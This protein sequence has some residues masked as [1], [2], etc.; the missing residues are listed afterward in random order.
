MSAA[1]L[2]AL[3]IVDL[4]SKVKALEEEVFRVRFQHA[5][6]QLQDAS[7]LSKTRRELARAKTVLRLKELGR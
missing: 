5:T 7:K 2:K 6:S 1:D 3:D 4:K